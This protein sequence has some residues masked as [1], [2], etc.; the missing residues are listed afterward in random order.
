M[1]E[2]FVVEKTVEIAASTHQVWRALTESDKIKQWMGGAQ[3]ESQWELGSEI[4][5]TGTM[6]NFNRKYKDYG[7]V[8]AVERE[9]FLQYSH[10]SEMSHRPDLHQNRT[11]TTLTLEDIGEK[12]CL[13][14]RH[15]NFKSDAEYKHANFFWG[16]AVYTLKNLLEHE[17]A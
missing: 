13:T 7:T 11:I 10:W 2:D 1:T 9:E 16:V 12:T 8:L 6:P 5:F 3:V 14:V 4:T 17:K 15:E